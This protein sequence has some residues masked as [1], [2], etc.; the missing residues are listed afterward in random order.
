MRRAFNEGH[1][2]GNHTFTHPDLTKVSFRQVRDEIKRTEDLIGAF[3][4]EHKPSRPPYGSPQ[5]RAA[6]TSSRA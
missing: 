2:I 6:R 4:T 5:W 3:M 1:I